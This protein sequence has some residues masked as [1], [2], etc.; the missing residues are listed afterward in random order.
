MYFEAVTPPLAVRTETQVAHVPTQ[1]EST[2]PRP[3]TRK[4]P[5]CARSSCAANRRKPQV[6]EQAQGS[7]ADPTGWFA[8]D[9]LVGCFFAFEVTSE[10]AIY[11]NMYYTC[12]C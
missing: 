2:Q 7:W 8:L 3:C 5:S 1:T 10:R 4:R 6:P 11:I 9:A 12:S